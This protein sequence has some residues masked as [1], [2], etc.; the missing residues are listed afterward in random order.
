VSH[1]RVD[2]V[3]VGGG[4]GGLGVAYYLA[5]L[6]VDFVV[7][8]RGQLGETW[9]S[10]RW[11]G[12]ALNTPNRINGL[13]GAPYE[14]PDPS[15]FM[16]HLELVASFETYADRFGLPVRTGVTVTSVGP[17]EGAGRYL[18]VGEAINGERVTYETDSVVIASGILQTPRVP[19]VS[20]HVPPEIVQLNTATYKSPDVLPEGGVVVVGGGQSGAQIVEELLTAGRDVYFSISKAGRVPRRYRGRDFM[21]WFLDLGMW[22]VATDEVSDPAILRAANPVVSG[23]G[24][25]GH[26][27]SY[28]HLAKQGVRLMGRLE[29]VVDGV[30]HTDG[31]V[32]EYIRNA[33]MQSQELAD[34]IEAFIVAHGLDVAESEPDPAD[35]PLNLDEDVEFLT[36]LSLAEAGIGTIIW[37]TGFIGDFSW[38][39]LPVFDASG[40]PIH[41]KGIARIPGIYFIGF[42]WLSKRKSGVVLGIDEDARHIGDAISRGLA[43]N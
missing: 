29:D 19:V 2:V 41:E 24:P 9:R 4:Q 28:Q 8:E 11:D 20:A 31:R 40:A 38:I 34:N 17:G 25:L 33:D 14:G 23:I 22:D 37:S 27:I 30:L 21:E 18:V 43:G 36:S 35:E 12:F 10:Q 1:I 42:P 16:T 6:G 7:L 15:G 3:V 39:D 26:T 5:Q 13:P 32:V